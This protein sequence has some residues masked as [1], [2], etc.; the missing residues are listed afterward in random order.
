MSLSFTRPLL[1]IGL[2]EGWKAVLFLPEQVN[3]V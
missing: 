2:D 1:G 3:A